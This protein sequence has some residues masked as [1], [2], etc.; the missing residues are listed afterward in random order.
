MSERTILTVTCSGTKKHQHR[1]THL[2]VYARDESGT[3]LPR[4]SGVRDET[5][6]VIVE[7]GIRVE[8]GQVDI[9]CPNNKCSYILRCSQSRTFEAFDVLTTRGL[10]EITGVFIDA[11]LAELARVTDNS[12]DQE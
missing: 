11:V 12:A 1:N 4:H 10:G 3:W 5:A 9:P 8:T 2:A 7:P 6:Y